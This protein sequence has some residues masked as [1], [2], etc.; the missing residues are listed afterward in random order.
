MVSL[1]KRI[2][3]PARSV[4]YG[5]F[6]LQ[7]RLRCWY[8]DRS[9]P[10]HESGLPVPPALLRFRVSELV[11]REEFLRIG[12]GTAM[13]IE[14]HLASMG[15]ELAQAGRVLDFGCGCGRTLRWFLRDYPQPEFHGADVDRDAIAWCR[16]HLQAA[17]FLA[18]GPQ[19]PL[20]YPDRHFDVIYCL[21]VFTHLDEVLQDAWL[22]ELGRL[23][24]TGGVLLLTVHGERAASL[25]DDQGR[26]TLTKAGFLHRRSKKLTGILPDW[27]Q[28]TWHS[29]EY[30]VNRLAA[31]FEDIRYHPLDDSMQVIVTA[32]AR[33]KP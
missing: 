3:G 11:S 23:L 22:A 33:A 29:R 17:R 19:P 25:L 2:P 28:T 30:I 18:N 31:H 14:Q 10:D 20:P 27:Y 1:R 8:A 13:R 5:L 12:L 4:Y 7:L 9:R 16:E 21:S 15:V 32:R 24:A 6:R 26:R